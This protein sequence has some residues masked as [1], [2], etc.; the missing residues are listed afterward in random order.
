ML[1]S[2]RILY[3]AP[4]RGYIFIFIME[5]EL[6]PI[7]VTLM[8]DDLIVMVLICDFDCFYVDEVITVR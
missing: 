6:I 8:F 2:R 3:L 1:L 5:M 4:K 7:I